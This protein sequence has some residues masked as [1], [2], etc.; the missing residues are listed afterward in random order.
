MRLLLLLLCLTGAITVG[1]AEEDAAPIT[2]EAFEA[3]LSLP[4]GVRVES[5][6]LLAVG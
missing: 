4:P 6:G 1:A 3:S 5:Y 2:R